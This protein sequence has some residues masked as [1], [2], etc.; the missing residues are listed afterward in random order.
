[1]ILGF[2]VKIVG[3]GRKVGRKEG[4]REMDFLLRNLNFVKWRRSRLFMALIPSAAYREPV[5]SNGYAI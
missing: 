4:R 2:S 1:M 3:V 5:G